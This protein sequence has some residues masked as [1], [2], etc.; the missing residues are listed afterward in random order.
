MSTESSLSATDCA[1][2]K[3]FQRRL[4][5]PSSF[6]GFLAGVQQHKEEHTFRDHYTAPEITHRQ[7]GVST[8]PESDTHLLFHK[9]HTDPT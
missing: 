1:L 7:E 6:Q 3:Y 5:G 4:S 9:P 8:F 2:C